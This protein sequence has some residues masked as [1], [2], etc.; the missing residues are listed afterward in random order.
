MVGDGR[1]QA[2]QRDP[3][4]WRNRW[5]TAT[6]FGPLDL[7]SAAM[8]GR[9]VLRPF[10][11]AFVAA[12]VEAVVL[13]LVVHDGSTATYVFSVSF[14]SFFLADA[15]A[16]VRTYS[17]PDAEWLLQVSLNAFMLTFVMFVGIV[18]AAAVGGHEILPSGGH[19][20]AR[21]RPAVLPTGGHWFCPR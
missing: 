4:L 8:P 21:W 9:V 18:G 13:W 14:A 11:L 3:G 20:A 17:G 6:V 19:V 7:E 12:A 15:G 10:A 5:A 16:L 1:A 2:A